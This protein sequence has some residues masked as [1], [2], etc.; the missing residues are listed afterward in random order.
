MKP[1]RGGA[2]QETQ[3]SKNVPE[4]RVENGTGVGR[5]RQRRWCPTRSSCAHSVPEKGSCS[6]RESRP[7]PGNEAAPAQFLASLS[8]KRWKSPG[9]R[10]PSS[11]RVM[12]RAVRK[13][14]HI[15]WTKIPAARGKTRHITWTKL[16]PKRR[17]TLR[18]L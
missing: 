15:T 4:R 5:R 7:V 12:A 1:L 3:Q 11:L 8:P 10:R 14:G 18:I 16:G 13:N 2:S 9:R 17:R 6:A